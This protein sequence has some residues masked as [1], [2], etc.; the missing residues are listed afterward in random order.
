M[1]PGV[2]PM[3]IP[4]C[5]S[6]V[7][8]GVLIGPSIKAYFSHLSLIPHRLNT[9]EDNTVTTYKTVTKNYLVAHF[10]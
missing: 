9:K 8:A 4:D 6:L 3:K 5:R 1:V 7:K 2:G 10:Y